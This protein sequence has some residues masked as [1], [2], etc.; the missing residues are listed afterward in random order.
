MHQIWHACVVFSRVPNVWCSDPGLQA[1]AV[2]RGLLCVVW[3]HLFNRAPVRADESQFQ[4]SA[5]KLLRS[6]HTRWEGSFFLHSARNS[7]SVQ[8]NSL[9]LRRVASGAGEALFSVPEDFAIP[10]VQLEYRSSNQRAPSAWSQ[11]GVNA[12]DASMRKLL[13]HLVKT[14]GSA[15]FL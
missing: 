7:R 3:G 15:T 11:H 13:N 2:S 14:V 5:S 10:L 8:R 9:L 6:S 1:S 4:S 12:K